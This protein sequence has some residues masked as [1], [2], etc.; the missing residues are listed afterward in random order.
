MIS[1]IP[2]IGDINKMGRT[3][4][5]FEQIPARFPEGTKDRIKATLAEGEKIADVIREAVERELKRRE[6][7]S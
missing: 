1:S 3:Q 2:S 7:K 6:R 4:I 5:N